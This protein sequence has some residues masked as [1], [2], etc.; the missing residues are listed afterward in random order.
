MIWDIYEDYEGFEN[1]EE[2]REA[3]I[4]GR[5]AELNGAVSDMLEVFLIGAKDDF[6]YEEEFDDLVSHFKEKTCEFLYRVCG[7]S[8][9]R[10][11]YLENEYG[12]L[13]YEEFPYDEIEY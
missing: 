9:Y 5:E 12:E 4:E 13:D 3:E 8:V 11:M 2:T 6:D 1:L 7:L 10:P